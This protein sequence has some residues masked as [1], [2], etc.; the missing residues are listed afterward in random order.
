VLTTIW[1]DLRYALRAFRTRPLHA[2]VTVLVLAIAIGA[3]TTVFSLINGLFLRPLPYPDGDRLVMVSNAY[4][5]LGLTAIGTSIPDY[6]DRRAQAPSLEELGIYS[7]AGRALAGEGPTQEIAVAMASPSLFGVLRIAPQLGRAFTEQEATPGN[8]GVAI[9]SHDLWVQRFGGRTDIVGKE[10]RLDGRTL[11]IIGVMPAGF[12]FPNRVVQAWVPYAFTPLQASDAGR[13]KEFSTSIGRLK[14]GATIAQL[15]SELGVIVRRVA[16]RLP[17]IQDAVTVAGFTGKAQP[18]RQAEVGN[19]SQLLLVLQAT[20]LAVLLIACANLANLQ[21]ARLTSRRRELT[22]RTTLGATR[23][24]LLRLVLVE[25]TVLAAVGAGV[26]LVVAYGGLALVRALG[27]DRAS[28]GYTFGFDLRVL[29]FTAGIAIVAA[30]GAGLLPALGAIRTSTAGI[31]HDAG[32]R[33]AGSRAARATRGTLVVV[34][35]AASVALLVGAGLLTRSFYDLRSAGAG[36][37]AEG[38]WTARVALPPSRYADSAAITRYFERALPELG[39][40]PGVSA[41][42]FTSDLPFGGGDNTTST[43]IDGYQPTDGASPPHAR[44]RIVNEGFFPS[45]G[46]RVIRGRNFAATEP[47]RVAIVDE[48]LAHK[49]WRDG[50]ALGQRLRRNLDPADQ[51]YTIVGIVSAVKHGTLAEDPGKETVY[52]HYLQRPAPNGAFTLRTTVA[53]DQLTRAASAAALRIDADVPLFGVAPLDTLVQRS[54][55]PQRAAMALT[56]LFAATAFT[57]AVIGIYGVLTWAVA[58]RVAEIGVRV[59]LG[60]RTTDVVR[61]VLTQGGR[62]I[63]LGLVIGGAVAV[64]LGR[65]LAA[66][67]Q[68][69]SALDPAVFIIAIG[70]LGAAALI[71]SWLPARHAASIDPMQALRSE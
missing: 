6:L 47:E 28:Q 19:L 2:G 5:K 17:S 48:N 14:P 32:R 37:A 9:V 66:Q 64:G 55:G 59:A 36:F 60:A 42:G 57:L 53:P 54:L 31:A 38:V 24:Q 29:G 34:Q 15:N 20:V 63:V 43:V 67:I 58:Q 18:W 65:A 40:L 51:W 70:G 26:G 12:A 61:M 22:L 62:L 4:E 49:Y 23:A 39:A 52:W 35:I 71:A 3:N 44:E 46:I 25:S 41:I 11:Q 13:G 33:T 30:L 21:L 50:D 8:D 16:D 7:V 1:Q 56:L 27:L 69:V 10:V 45:L 68:T